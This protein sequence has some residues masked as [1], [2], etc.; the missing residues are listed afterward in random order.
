MEIVS[1]EPINRQQ[2]LAALA[3]TRLRGFDGVQPYKNAAMELLP[4]VETDTLA[5]SQNYVLK[6]GIDKI[7]ELREA[8]LKTGL[9]MFALDGGAYV[10]TS[11]DPDEVIPV[12]PPV[13]E[14]SFEPDGR[15]VR[16][17]NDGIHR[18]FAARSLGLRIS[19]VY[20]EDVPREYPY[21]AYAL[22]D[23]WSQVTVMDELPDKHLRKEYRQPTGYRAL[24][25]DF[26]EV[27]PG[28]QKER[29]KSDPTHITE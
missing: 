12:I 24:Y 2:L 10:R 16:I 8:L 3:R 14:E 22:R 15:V 6:P 1:V 9:D 19:V 29:K 25:R 13:V 17:I 11:D 20:V 21:Y 5:P 26:N 18:V 7:L 28:V 27:F 4:A 23:G